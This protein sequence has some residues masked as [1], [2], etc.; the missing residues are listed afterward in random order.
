M[1]RILM[2][3]PLLIC[4]AML[5]SAGGD[6]GGKTDTE[7]PIKVTYT[8]WE[9]PTYLNIIDAF[10][11]SQERIRVEA[12]QIASGDYE[13]KIATLLAGGTPMDVYMQ[14]RQ[15]DMFVH[16]ANGYI[17]PLDRLIADYRY[18]LDMIAPYIAHVTVDDTIYGI[19]FRGSSYYTY[20]NRNIFDAAGEPYPEYW[21]ERNEWTWDKFA[22]VSKKLASGD[23]TVYG[24]LI[25]TWPTNNYMPAA[26][27]GIDI[28]TRNGE[29]DVDDSLLTAFLIRKELEDEK[30]MWPLIDLKVTKTHYSQ[31]F[32]GGNVGILLIGEWFPG[33]MIKGRDENL[34]QG[35]T[36][37]D[38]GVTRLPS[39]EP[40]YA[41]MGASTFNHINARSRNKDA[42]FE[43]LAWM[44]GPE[45]AVVVARNG[46]LPPVVTD[47][48]VAALAESIPDETSLQYFL[49]K[50]PVN[51]TAYNK[52]GSQ[53]ELFL[54]DV[55]EEFLVEMVAESEL[56]E[57]IIAGLEDIIA[58]TD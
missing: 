1:K 16:A 38:W 52:Y 22:E 5:W 21:I 4:T 24:S 47:D 6:D 26:Q 14:K 37:N 11:S 27:R 15:T 23:G 35:F 48:V 19:P 56:E 44:G 36:W 10:N 20:Y 18:D 40:E 54:G 2:V 33:F 41:S 3:M 57:R 50:K 31:A 49:E 29:L 42:A 53:V 58:T 25:Y 9:D 28:I 34:L 12:E 55:L 51:S 43:L 46:F 45:G 39:N 8:M 30:A 17:E 13:T 32:Y 7:G